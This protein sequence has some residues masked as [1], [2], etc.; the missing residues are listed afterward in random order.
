MLVLHEVLIHR[1]AW[2]KQCRNGS[3]I[4]GRKLRTDKCLLLHEFTRSNTFQSL[5]TE[6]IFQCYVE[7]ME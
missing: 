2:N 3:R 4:S 5:L 7:Q 1:T 6:A